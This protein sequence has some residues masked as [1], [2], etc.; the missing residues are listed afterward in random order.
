M[1]GILRRAVQLAWYSGN[2]GQTVLPP[3]PVTADPPNEVLKELQLLKRY[4]PPGPGELPPALFKDGGDFL[5]K[6]LIVL[7]TKV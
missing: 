7:F 4:K 1:S 2:I 6:E 5:A 3:W